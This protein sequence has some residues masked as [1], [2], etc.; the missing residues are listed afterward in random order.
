MEQEWAPYNP[1]RTYRR[2]GRVRSV[3]RRWRRIGATTREPARTRAAPWPH[4]PYGARGAAQAYNPRTGAYGAT[5]QGSGVYGSWGTTGVQRGDDWAQTSRVTNTRTGNDDARDA[6]ERRRLGGYAQH[7]WHRRSFAGQSG[8]G[9]V[10]AGHD[11]NV[12]RKQGDSWQKYDNGGWN[13]V[14]AADAPAAR[15]GAGPR[16]AGG[17]NARDWSAGRHGF[18]DGRSAQSRFGGAQQRHA[19]HARRRH[20]AQRR[21]ASRSGSYRPSGGGSAVAASAAA[22]DVVAKIRRFRRRP[23]A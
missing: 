1:A 13:N 16:V 7:G 3:R 19:A 12:Y 2:R 21:G 22:A 10:Y 5:R 8:S 4:G 11:G 23:N 6:G 17:A 18:R 14:T 15:G 20:R 9:D